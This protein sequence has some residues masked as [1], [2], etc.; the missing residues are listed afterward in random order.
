MSSDSADGFDN[1]CVVCFKNVDIYSVGSCDHM[2]CYECSTRMRVLCRQNECPICRQDLPKVIFSYSL[3]PFSEIVNSASYEDKKYKIHFQNKKIQDAFYKLLEHSCSICQNR[4][5]KTFQHLY[6]HMRREHELYYCDLCVEH[7]R[8]FTSERRSYTKADLSQHRRKGDPDDRSHR[9]HPLCEFCQVRFMDNDFLYRHLRK[10]HLF[11]HFCDADGHDLYYSSYDYLRDH[12]REEHYLCEEGACIDEKFTPVFRTEIDLKAH[13]MSVHGRTMG[14]AAAKQARTLELEFTLKPRPRQQENSRKG[15]PSQFDA[16]SSAE[17][18]AAPSEEPTPRTHSPALDPSDFPSL[19]SGSGKVTVTP[20]PARRGR[21]GA[22]TIQAVGRRNAPLAFTDE[23]FPVLGDYNDNT[24]GTSVR[25]NINQDRSNYSGRSGSVGAPRNVSIHVNH[26]ANGEQNIRIRQDEFPALPAGTSASCI[27]AAKWVSVNNK[28][29][30]N[31]ASKQDKQTKQ[32]LT[33]GD[34]PSLNSKFNAHLSLKSSESSKPNNAD[35]RSGKGE[36]KGAKKVSSVV[37]PVRD[38]WL[39]VSEAGPS[40]SKAKVKKKKSKGNANED[41]AKK[42]EDTNVKN[43]KGSSNSVGSNSSAFVESSNSGSSSTKLVKPLP[44]AEDWFGDTKKLLASSAKEDDREDQA[45]KTDV[46]FDVL[47][48]ANGKA[49]SEQRSKKGGTPKKSREQSSSTNRKQD[50]KAPPGFDQL[51]GF[52]KNKDGAKPPPGF[53]FDFPRS[54]GLTFTNSSGQSFAIQTDYNYTPPLNFEKRNQDLVS[55]VFGILLNDSNLEQFKRM[56]ALFRQDM[57]S[58]DD[59]CNH[60][61]KT[62]G[63][64]GFREIFPELLILLP[65]IGK[66]QE[67]FQVFSR[68]PKFDVEKTKLQSCEICRQVLCKS[69]IKEHITQH[70]LQENFPLL[71]PNTWTK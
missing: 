4:Q 9:G 65:D 40:S 48:V 39:D 26:K 44:T 55:S 49:S 61:I 17:G 31:S 23:N 27:P 2:V 25:L 19:P 54:N 18:A 57:L 13:R 51:N 46:K 14:K 50:S 32:P 45:Q 66:Q 7:L 24:Q 62:M 33:D 15:K 53:A 28:K 10:D 20:G 68:Y 29:T 60:C 42:K 3:K 56:S 63:E 59:Y 69:D 16:G 38:D 34:F 37:I 30:G 5:F 43:A 47:A 22:L 58:A 64:D 12:F 71:M 36:G 6:D 67:L 35:T 1:L 11:C 41:T 21:T 70:T 52:S 8:I